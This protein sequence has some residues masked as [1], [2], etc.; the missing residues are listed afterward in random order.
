MNLARACNLLLDAALPDWIQLLPAG[1]AIQGADGRGWTLPDPS[2]LITA[3][4]QRKTPLVIDWEHASEH[5]APQGLDAPAAGWIDQLELRNGGQI[6]GHVE[7][8]ARAVQQIHDREYRYLS[9]VFTYRKDNQHIVA[10]TSVALTNQPNLDLKALNREESPMSLLNAL[11]VALDLTGAPDEEQVVAA[12]KTL[13]TEL[14][15][16]QQRMDT[17][18]LDKF[19][20]R[21]DFDVVM[22][23]ATNAETKLAEIEKTQREAQVTALIDQGLRER[24]ISPATQDYYTAMC[25]YEGG[26]D[27]FK[28][29][30]DKA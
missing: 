29:F 9:P 18:P 15:T 26:V 6:W 7:W 25:G 24:K 19:V 13:K 23:R 14:A 4:Q 16:A 5:R 22:A 2:A 11:R 17:P 3:F 10:L 28:A 12:A 27:Q 30:L 20:P 21:A 8:T 1:P